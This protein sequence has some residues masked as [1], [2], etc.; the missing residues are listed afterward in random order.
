[1]KNR[2]GAWQVGGDSDKGKVEFRLFFPPGVDPQIASIQVAGDF[3]KCLGLSADWDFPQGFPLARVDKPEGTFWSYCTNA[4]LASGFYQYKY[5][6]RFT[7]GEAQIVS[8]PCARY[9]GTDHQNA[10]FVIGGSSPADNTVLPLQGGRKHLRDLIVYELMID[11][12]TDEYRGAKAPLAA[13]IDKLDYLKG[14]GFNAILFMPWTAWKNRDFD[15][16]YEPFQ[17]FAVEYRYANDIEKPAEKISWLKRLI[18]A[19]HERGIHVIMDG[20]FNHVSVDFPYKGLYRN[21]EECPYT[22]TYGETF[23]GLQDLNF[24][25]DCTHE[26]IR[27]VCLYWI[28]IFGIDGIRFD[29]TVNYYVAGDLNGLPRVMIDIQDHL[30]ASQATT[31]SLTLEHLNKD[32]VQITKTTRATSYWDNA[33]YEQT[34]G[35]LWWNQIQPAFLNAL[36][37]QRWLDTIEKVPTIYL[38]NHDHSHVTWQAGARENLGAMKWFTTQPYVIALY[39][40]PASPMVQNGQEFGEDHWLMEADDGTGRRVLPRPLRWKLSNDKIGTALSRLYR[41]MAEIRLQYAGLRSPNF[42]PQPWEE[43]QTQFNPQGYGIDVSRQIAIYRRWGHDDQG[44]LEQFVV[45]L[46]FSDARQE[47]SVPFPENGQWV[48]LLSDYCGS[49]RPVVHDRRLV[50]TVG[51]NWGHVFYK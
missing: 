49:W 48:D 32:A 46:N 27:D 47:V 42:E 34:F 37:N 9:G 13:V 15:W 22:G 43:W 45:V 24:A 2:L 23:P 18:S 6:V 12:F 5:L 26:F 17:Y 7:D 40:S 1:M 19:C 14:L 30:G 16:G 51:S 44:N 31:F 33:L 25:N 20:V 10:G 41:R 11:D 38:S 39:T 29:N 8:D 3:Q 35:S 36:N 28:D 50:F 4:E 21:P